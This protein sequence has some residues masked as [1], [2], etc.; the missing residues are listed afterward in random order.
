MMLNKFSKHQDY[1]EVNNNFRIFYTPRIFE[2]TTKA[3]FDAEIIEAI[4]WT[5]DVTWDDVYEFQ[6]VGV[7]IA[8]FDGIRHL[9]IGEDGEGYIYYPNFNH[10]R[11]VL[12]ALEDLQ[13][14]FCEL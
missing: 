13:S 1:V 11:E 6:N 5:G 2:G 14:K 3:G 4:S 12:T 9:N 8:M 7:A 10:W